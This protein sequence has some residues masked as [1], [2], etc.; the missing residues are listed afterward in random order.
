MS[1]IL[2]P[3]TPDDC[4]LIVAFI[5]ELAAYEKLSHECLTTDELVMASAFPAQG[6]PLIYIVIAEQAESKKPAGFCLYFFNYSTFTEDLFV[7]PEFRKGGLGTMFFD[8]LK[9]LA[10]EKNCT[11]VEWAV[12]DWNTPAR[13]FY[14]KKIGAVEKSEWILN[15]IDGDRL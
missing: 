11:R 9:A 12:I 10:R 1:F 8:H 6:T 2:R 15:R 5:Q 3:A 14:T 7:R 4:P 13:D